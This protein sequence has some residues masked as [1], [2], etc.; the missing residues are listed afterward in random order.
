MPGAAPVLLFLCGRSRCS[1]LYS[2][3]YVVHHATFDMFD[4][5]FDIKEREA[6]RLP[7]GRSDFRFKLTLEELEEQQDGDDGISDN[8]G[9][10]HPL[11]SRA[12]GFSET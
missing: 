3:I 4:M 8:R 11:D 10:P 2:C 5:M 9:G 7:G 6:W 1:L 12:A